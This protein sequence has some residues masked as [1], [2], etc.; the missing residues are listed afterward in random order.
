MLQ[1]TINYQLLLRLLMC[2][3]TPYM[4]L[5]ISEGISKVETKAQLLLDKFA[6]RVYHL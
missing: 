3:N 4:L 6:L 2:P 5:V 1:I